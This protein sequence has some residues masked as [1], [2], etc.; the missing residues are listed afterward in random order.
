[1]KR[2]WGLFVIL[3]VLVLILPVSEASATELYSGSCGDVFWRYS[4][5]TLYIYGEGAME[6]LSSQSEQPW[7]H[8]AASVNTVYIE[9]GV[10]HIGDYSFSNFPYLVTLQLP[11]TLQQI[12]T[13]AFYHCES[14]A[15]IFN[16]S[17]EEKLP[18][19]VHTI[20]P[21]AF[22]Y[23]TSITNL[24]LGNN[25]QTIGSGAFSNCSSLVQISFSPSLEEIGDFAFY[26]CNQLGTLLFPSS[27]TYIGEQSFFNGRNVGNIYFTGAVPS[28]YDTAFLDV[29]AVV[30]C[31]DSWDVA[32]RK[33]YG[34]ALTWQTIPAGYWV[35]GSCGENVSWG[36]D[37]YGQL[38]VFGTGPMYDYDTIDYA[39]WYA[40]EQKITSVVVKEGVTT[41]GS[42]AFYKCKSVAQ[43]SLPDSVTS[44][45]NDAFFDCDSLNHI[46]IG[47]NVTDIGECALAVCNALTFI[48][49]AQ[50]NPCYE[51]DS[52]GC[53]YNKEMQL[54]IQ[55]PG[56]LSGH[57]EI[58]Y[59]VT[60]IGEFA[61]GSNELMTSVT[62]PTSV[63][64]I[65][66]SAFMCCWGLTEI[67]IPESVTHINH[68]AFW[69]CQNLIELQFLGDAPVF[70]GDEIF[71]QVSAT[72][73]YPAGNSTWTDDKF[74]HT[75]SAITWMAAEMEAQAF[76]VPNANNAIFYTL[77]HAINFYDPQ[78]QYIQLL[79]D[80]C[81]EITLEKDLLL[82]LNGHILSGKI[83]T[84]EYSV[85][86]MDSTTD[87][88]SCDE[89]GYFTC[90][91]PLGI[92]VIPQRAYQRHA[93]QYLSISTESGYS[94]HRFHFEITH[95]SLDPANTAFGYKALF[96]ANKMVVAEIQAMGYRLWLGE[97][98]PITRTLSGTRSWLTLRLKNFDVTN[99]GETPV[100]AQPIMTLKDGTVI[101][102]QT[103]ATT[104]RSVL[105]HISQNFSDYST[106]QQAAVKEIAEKYPII[107]TWDTANL[108]A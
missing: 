35:G 29:N 100:Y 53:L 73:T 44:L 64:V 77:E 20:A 54:L 40:I 18:D 79:D 58:P 62:I 90:C 6:D 101:A 19:S 3:F 59:G 26:N 4:K 52:Q 33:N 71:V 81:V 11:D 17:L 82:D 63:T 88:Y 84:G 104:M 38:T 9:N 28:I 2:F 21:D 80:A 83:D 1:M 75:N 27:L 34:G 89:I 106:V 94:F 87:Y 13:A 65:G 69:Y 86:G 47:A 23:C 93:G 66:N 32:M 76:C 97:N 49:V 78:A 70:E 92:P 72:A 74:V 48:S 46:E 39:P 42:T 55:I 25:V 10:T 45:G 107:K 99:C 36:L 16:S 7:I 105:E 31:P 98:Q 57:L 68:A 56:G 91:D 22:A 24:T 108:Y 95:M 37:A 51:S 103:T 96:Y 30:H 41:I 85:Y 14:L 15:W 5:R 8:L 50:D 67:T 12:G 43:V 102:G 60:Q 61:A